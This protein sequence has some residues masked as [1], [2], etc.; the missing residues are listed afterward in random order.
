M[1][2]QQYDRNGRALDPRDFHDFN[3]IDSSVHFD[4]KTRH[5][6]IKS[7]TWI[8]HAKWRK[9]KGSGRMNEHNKQAAVPVLRE[10]E[11]ITT[12]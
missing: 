5:D 9:A 7:E 12:L 1:S 10:R 3:K 11:S 4:P 6:D 2:N 8:M